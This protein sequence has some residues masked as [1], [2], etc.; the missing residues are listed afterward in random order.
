MLNDPEGGPSAH[1]FFVGSRDAILVHDADGT[2]VDANPAAERLYGCETAQLQGQSV[3]TLRA[4]DIEMDLPTVADGNGETTW[5][6]SGPDGGRRRLDVTVRRSADSDHLLSFARVADGDTPADGRG[7]APFRE[8]QETV[9]RRDLNFDEKV[10]AL[11]ELGRE[12]LGLSVGY[13]THID[14]DTQTVD[15]AVGD[16]DGIQQGETAPLS[17]TYC[18]HTLAAGNPV[19]TIESAEEAG[20][21]DSEEYAHLGLSCYIGGTISVDETDYGTICF[22][23]TE[24]RSRPFTDREETFVDLLAQWVGLTIERR[25]QASK[26][27]DEHELTTAILESSPTG[28]LVL[29]EDGVVT[30]ANDRASDLLGEGTALAGE[31]GLPVT[32]YDE[33]GPVSD[34]DT[35][36]KRIEREGSLSNVE[37]RL[38]EAA[39]AQSLSLAGRPLDA[40]RR[41]GV[42]LTVE[43]V[44]D[45]RRHIDAMRALSDTLATATGSFDVQLRSLLEIGR[46]HLGIAN[47]HLTE[48]D[49]DRHEIVA[50]EGLDGLLEVGAQSSLSETF[51]QSVIE[52]DGMCTVTE[53]STELSNPTPYEEWGLETYIG[54][55][56]TVDGETYGTICF[57]DPDPRKRAFK[58]WEQ[59][60]VETLGRWVETQIR[61]RRAA[62]ERDRDRALLE[63][64]FNSQRTQVGIID[65][66]GLVVDAN[67]A[68]RSFIDSTPAEL[69]GTPVWETPWFASE[70]AQ[71]RCREGFN[72]ALEGKMTD[73][74]VRYESESGPREFSVNLRPVFEDGAVINVVIEGYDITELRERER[75]LQRR[76]VHID[77]I[78]NNVPLVLFAVDEDGEFLHSRGRALSALGL[79]DDELVGT[80]IH[81]EYGA[82]PGIIEDYERARSGEPVESVRSVGESVFRTWY[83]QVAIG[84]ESHVIGIGIDITE[85]QR[86]KERVAAVNRAA[87]ELMYAHTPEAVG[88]TLVE[89]VGDLL[90]YPLAGVWIPDDGDESLS[91]VAAT[92]RTLELLGADA[93]EDALPPIEPGSLE[94]SVFE[95]GETRVI[96]EYAATDGEMGR[97]TPIETVVMVPLGEHGVLHVGSPTPDPPTDTELDLIGILARNAEAALVSTNRE[98]ELAA[99]RDELERS[100]QAL[101]E[102]AYIA[103][104]DLQEPLRMVSSYVDLLESEYG[105][106]FDDEAS[107]YMTFAIDGARRMQN[108]IDALLRYSRVETR[109]GAI[110]RTETAAIVEGVRD[111]LQLR[112]EETGATVDIGSLPPVSADPDQLGQLFQNLV[113]NAIEYADESG[114]DP[115]IEVDAWR[116]DNTVQFSVSDNGPGIPA[117]MDE[118]V[119]EIFNRGGNHNRDGTGIGLAVCRRIVRRHDGEIWVDQSGGAG[120]TFRFTLPA[121]SEVTGDD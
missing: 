29:N 46:T 107:E 57:V 42:V 78:L 80:D 119:F 43:D 75:E 79:D 74:E 55:T 5:A 7:H 82:T 59:T 20:I 101:Q 25:E 14:S 105:D 49:G 104:H 33:H 12:W 3:T 93:V 50:T 69:A 91:P 34:R 36:R 67:A 70:P 62:A 61:Q 65:T 81:D 97:D 21:L 103:S 28:I 64:V 11:L 58:P 48:I 24:S 16:H 89:I 6:V 73:F 52:R 10:T 118:D 9:S 90:S 96:E 95:A 35:P 23:D 2:V 106:Q 47:G 17:E 4:D 41:G 51:C 13:M 40:D 115:A 71:S 102:F 113:E 39:D 77:A 38:G 92:D 86:Q 84:G 66:D 120:A 88:E 54:T 116:E 76:Q 85:Q 72:R 110:E 63:G 108:M 117:R 27:R 31:H 83:R 15:S 44:T 94:R 1:D 112:I 99:Y 53:A 19:R 109:G 111:A 60:F 22:A 8:L 56:V 68:A 18:Q 45:R 100:N 26:L 87:E 98:Q 32:L 37:Y 30:L 121:P 114:V